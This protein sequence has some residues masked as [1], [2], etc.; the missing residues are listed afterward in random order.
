MSRRV[1]DLHGAEQ[2]GVVVL[3]DHRAGLEEDVAPAHHGLDRDDVGIDEPQRHG[4]LVDVVVEEVTTGA[5][6][7]EPPA[8][9]LG[10][11]RG[12]ER[13]VGLADDGL[14]PQA[15]GPADGSLRDEL[16]GRLERGVVHEALADPQGEPRRV[17]QASELQGFVD[18]IGD[19]LLHR[20]VLPGRQRSLDV[21]V[22]Q[23][24]G[25]EDLDGVDVVVGEELVDVGARPGHPPALGGLGGQRAV[26]VTDGQHL[27]IGVLQVA[28]DVHV[29][30]VPGAENTESELARAARSSPWDPLVVIARQSPTIRRLAM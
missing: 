12:L 17:G 5:P 9:S 8:V 24:R 27:T 29:G 28:G 20:D 26:D 18:G 1:L 4:V 14:D 13:R 15:D 16:L 25:G 2:L 22:V 30:D 10:A 3:E 11:K 21:R 7:V 19:G 6:L 23:V